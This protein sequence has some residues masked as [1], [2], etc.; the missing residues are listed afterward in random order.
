MQLRNTSSVMAPEKYALLDEYREEVA[1]FYVSQLYK[2]DEVSIAA[3]RT[4]LGRNDITDFVAKLVDASVIVEDTVTESSGGTKTVY[5]RNEG[6]I[7]PGVNISEEDYNALAA[8]RFA[9]V[10]FYVVQLR[11]SKPVS[12]AVLRALGGRNNVKPYIQ[13]LMGL[14]LL[15]AEYSKK[16]G[17]DS[18]RYLRT[19]KLWNEDPELVDQPVPTTHADAYTLFIAEIKRAEVGR[20]IRTSKIRNSID[21]VVYNELLRTAIGQGWIAK[22][23]SSKYLRYT[24]LTEPT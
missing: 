6:K 2:G 12:K 9:V 11:P 15:K 23:E 1:M 20:W 3:L 22:D 4:I 17:A 16:H 19:Y 13:R 24:K 7:P 10:S 8:I 5:S 21:P 18:G 14:D